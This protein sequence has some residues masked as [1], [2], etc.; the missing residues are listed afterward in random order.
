MKII[1][2][3]PNVVIGSRTVTEY[4]FQI[5]NFMNLLRDVIENDNDF[6]SF[7]YSNLDPWCHNLQFEIGRV[8]KEEA[9]K[10]WHY[11]MNKIYSK[12]NAIQVNLRTNSSK[13][14][15]HLCLK[16]WDELLKELTKVFDL[17]YNLK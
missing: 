5:L 9:I 1:P 14:T 7:S 11:N 12:I 8:E 4:K 3:Y 17:K 10:I 16:I 13:E 6:S 2:N 15:K